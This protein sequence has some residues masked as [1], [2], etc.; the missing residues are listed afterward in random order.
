MELIFKDDSQNSVQKQGFINYFHRLMPLLSGRDESIS[1]PLKNKALLDRVNLNKSKYEQML[2][3]QK[4]TEQFNELIPG[5][6]TAIFSI[7][8]SFGIDKGLKALKSALIKAD[9]KGIS[10]SQKRSDFVVEKTLDPFKSNKTT[11]QSANFIH[12]FYN[13]E[14]KESQG[15]VSNSDSFFE[16]NESFSD[17]FEDMNKTLVQ[18]LQKSEKEQAQQ[19][20]KA[21]EQIRAQQKQAELTQQTINKDQA[22]ELTQQT[23]NKS[24]T[25][26]AQQEFIEKA[27]EQKKGLPIYMSCVE[28]EK[29]EKQKLDE[30]QKLEQ[31]AQKKEFEI[32][33]K[34]KEKMIKMCDEYIDKIKEVEKQQQTKN[35]EEYLKKQEV[36]AIL[37][38]L[39]KPIQKDLIKKIRALRRIKRKQLIKFLTTYR[40]FFSKIKANLKKLVKKVI[41][42]FAA[43]FFK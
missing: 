33:E 21:N 32:N 31:I 28:L 34:A 22:I 42:F 19:N 16:D 38:K 14:L 41:S 8:S 36:V 30:V 1:N 10:H 3:E 12:V 23:M 6:R 11:K 13:E 27:I 17:L 20:I 18:Q 25:Q 9:L 39:P 43:K 26:E 15:F 2:S 37:K 4:L 7:F 24:K 5:A 40:L 35:P 29:M